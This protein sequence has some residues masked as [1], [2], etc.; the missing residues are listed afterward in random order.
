MYYMDESLSSLQFE[1]RCIIIYNE[2]KNKHFILSVLGFFSKMYRYIAILFSFTSFD[3]IIVCLQK[4]GVCFCGIYWISVGQ[5]LWIWIHFLVYW[6]FNLM[7]SA[8]GIQNKPAAWIS[9]FVGMVNR[10]SENSYRLKEV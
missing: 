7:D 1:G 10:E 3:L 5:F 4:R 2:E 8:V 9:W 6:G